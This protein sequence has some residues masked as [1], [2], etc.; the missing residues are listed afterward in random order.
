MNYQNF[1]FNCGES[2]SVE[3]C[4]HCGYSFSIPLTCPR[5]INGN[6]IA[7]IHTRKLCRNKNNFEECEIF[8]KNN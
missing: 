4:P 1:C 7:C 3:V 6:G 5:L 8:R 2:I